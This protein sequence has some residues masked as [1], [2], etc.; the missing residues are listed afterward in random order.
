MPRRNNHAW[1]FAYIKNSISNG[2]IAVKV[3][4]NIGFFLKDKNGKLVMDVT[5]DRGRGC[6]AV[7]ARSSSSTGSMVAVPW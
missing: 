3:W 5:I 7:V 1:H 4:K 6:E 2:A